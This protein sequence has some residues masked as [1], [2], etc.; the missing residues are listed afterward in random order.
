MSQVALD[1]KI[2][3]IAQAQKDSSELIKRTICRVPEPAAATSPAST[4]AP[5]AAVSE[6]FLSSMSALSQD[7]TR[8]V[9]SA[10]SSV[11]DKLESNIVFFKEQ[12]DNERN[13]K[14]AAKEK[15]EHIQMVLNESM[16]KEA[17]A[18][19]RAE[20]LE[21]GID[22]VRK[23]NKMLYELS[24]ALRAECKDLMK[25]ALQS[26]SSRKKDRAE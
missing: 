3:E 25:T 6:I 9:V 21:A 4:T 23:S 8:S 24:E 5:S 12:L 13:E 11:N 2:S 26:L 18:H 7:L 14:M 19:A 16:K 1:A 20:A 17:A 15:V 22:E 10:H